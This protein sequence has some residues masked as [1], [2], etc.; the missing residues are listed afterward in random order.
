MNHKIFKPISIAVLFFFMWSFAGFCQIAYAV[1]QHLIKESPINHRLSKSETP[2]ERFQKAIEELEEILDTPEVDREIK[3]KR[4][5]GKRAEIEELDTEIRKQ[6]AETEKKLKEAGL[7]DEI[8]QRH[9]RFVKHY[10]DNLKELRENLG[11]IEKAERGVAA[12]VEMEKAKRHLERVKTPK[13]HIPLDPNKLPHRT[14]KVERREP[15]LKKEDFE[16]DFVKPKKA[17]NEEKPLLVANNGPLKGILSPNPSPLRQT[18]IS[19]QA[20]NS[21]LAQTAN[22]PT[23]EDLGE[24]IEVQFTPE[25]RAKA[26]ELEY[27]PVKIYNWV[28]NN[29]EFVPTYG[30]IQGAQMTLLTKQGNA[31]DTAS[32]L[33]ALLRA[34]NIPAR[35]V[36]GT[37]E[38]PIDRVMNWVGGFTDANSALDFIASGG[39]PVTGIIVGGKITFAKLEHVWVEAFVPYGN[40]RGTM[41]DQSIKTWIPID[42]S[43]KQYSYKDPIDFPATLG[44]DIQAFVNEIQSASTIDPSNSSISNVP[45]DLIL[46]RIR[47]YV[48]N[49]HQYYDSN[50]QDKTAEAILGSKKVLA[51]EDPYLLGTLPYKTILVGNKFSQVPDFLR[52]RIKFEIINSIYSLEL[53]FSY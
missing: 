46:Q 13:R 7:P 50:L 19:G 48:R 29:I 37:I 8:L 15:R 28:R 30:S 23:P 45:Q 16:K 36:H 4:A 22:Q 34:S 32:L 27:N 41:R 18:Q 17:Q 12:G 20:P 33:I 44:L 40:Y 49:A 25:I 1:D 21:H 6:F 38:L 42:G 10:E 53:D 2:E 14:P 24:T 39:I 47:D 52:W 51:K 5:K 9:Y 31:F 43:Y 11:A 3:A 26:Q 35:Y